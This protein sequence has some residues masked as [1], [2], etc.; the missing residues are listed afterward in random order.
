MEALLTSTLAV[1]IAE[2]GDKTQL[3]AF[4]LAT[5]F[6]KPLPII[7]GIFVATIANHAAAAWVGDWVAGLISPVVLTWIVG[8]SFIAVAIWIL[9]P[10]KADDEENKLY[11][12]GPFIASLVLFFIAEIGD[13][14]QVA[15]VLLAA[16]YDELFM[17]IIGT[18][19]GMLLANVPVVFAG[20]FSADKLPLTWIRGITCALFTIMGIS[21]LI[22][23]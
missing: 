7:A 9:V 11:Q 2:I 14:T 17:V 23:A 18:T 20:K 19:L 10:D 1:A 12:Y 15:T 8:L 3:L 4:L 16:R 6:R 5:R 22:W 21:T 13:K